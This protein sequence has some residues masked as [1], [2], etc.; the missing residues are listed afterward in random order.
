M[1]SKD[2]LKPTTMRYLVELA[3]YC[4]QSMKE[5]QKVPEDQL[6]AKLL[7]TILSEWKDI[8]LGNHKQDALIESMLGNLR[9][10]T[11]LPEETEHLYDISKR[12][13]LDKL[14]ELFDS[15]ESLCDINELEGYN[16]EEEVDS[17]LL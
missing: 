7:E 16:S 9:I 15:T 4:L 11:K 2:L 17:E 5:Q 1:I 8:S 3:N 10:S 14:E 6:K 13:N 12:A